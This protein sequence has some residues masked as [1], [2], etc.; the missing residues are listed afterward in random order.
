MSTQGY[1]DSTATSSRHITSRRTSNVLGGSVNSDED[2]TKVTDTAERRRIQNRIAQRNYRKKLKS[3]L[4]NLERRVESSS[5]SQPQINKDL[6]HQQYWN[7]SIQ[8]HEGTSGI[9]RQPS[10]T[11]LPSQRT[12]TMEVRDPE[13]GESGVYPPYRQQPYHPVTTGGQFGGLL[14]PFPAPL[15]SAMLFHATVKQKDYTMSQFDTYHSEIG[16]TSHEYEDINPHTLPLSH[17]Y[18]RLTTCSESGDQYVS[19]YD[20]YYKY[21]VLG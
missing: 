3:R 13:R 17:P 14:I 7:E 10:P 2:W 1:S 15:P 6:H 21:E 8:N 5:T 18:E 12:R 9:H 4:E 20:F 11:A 19:L 16:H